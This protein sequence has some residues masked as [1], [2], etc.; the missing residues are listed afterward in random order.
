MELSK[1][2]KEVLKKAKDANAREIEFDI[3]VDLSY[4]DAKNTMLWVNPESKNRVKF[5]VYRPE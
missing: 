1:Y 2:I 3:G 5:V 4:I